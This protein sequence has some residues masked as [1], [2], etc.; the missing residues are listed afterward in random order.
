[1][2]FPVDKDE[3]ISPIIIQTKK[4]MEDI[5]VC[6]DYRILN[7]ACV[8]D[9]FPTPFSDEVLDQVA[10]TKHIPLQMVFLD[11]TRFESP[12]KTRKILPSLLS[13]DHFPI[14]LCLLGSR[15]PQQCS[16]R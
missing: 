14:M 6:V 1:M 8:H 4:G 15:I 3:W 13:G 9:P 5:Q 16:L 12:K 10:E 7:V 2:I 11:T